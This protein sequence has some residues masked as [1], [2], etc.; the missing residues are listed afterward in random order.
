MTLEE[1]KAVRNILKHNHSLN[2]TYLSLFEMTF[3]ITKTYM[4]L[5]KE[6]SDGNCCL[7]IDISIICFVLIIISSDHTYKTNSFVLD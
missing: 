3:S 4:S 2:N 5:K 6:N 7:V 1:K